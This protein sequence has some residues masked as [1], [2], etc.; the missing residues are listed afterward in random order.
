MKIIFKG[1]FDGNADSLPYRPHKEGA[2]KFIECDNSTELAKKVSKYGLY[3]S[4]II[5]AIVLVYSA[6]ADYPLR[7]NFLALIPF[8]ISM[9]VH[10]FLHAICF[11]EEA[12]I[13]TNLKQG[14]LFVV[15]NEDMSRGR[16]V[17]MSLLPNII[18]GLIPLLLF[19]A[20]PSSS[21]LGTYAIFAIPAGVGDYYNV[22]NAMTQMP[23]G[24]RTY[25]H[26]FNSYWY[27]PQE[28]SNG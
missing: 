17:F 16:Y 19:F 3:L 1:K 13:Y 14:M 8:I 26:K 27:M 23:N 9:I 15:G 28:V 6:V 21:I 5:G 20:F 25:L 4:V 11:K 22:Y 7:I 18:L 2:V 24:A 12:F 10:E